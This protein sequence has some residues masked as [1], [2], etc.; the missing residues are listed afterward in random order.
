MRLGI[1]ASNIR[2][3]G[4]IIHLQ[5]IL[6]QAEPKKHLINRVVVWGG[7]TSLDNLPDKPWLELRKIPN[8]N[9]QTSQRL[10]WQQTI[11]GK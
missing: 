5:K 6:E 8:L 9:Q 3:G 2:S 4:G 1:D 10:F 11:F 7:D